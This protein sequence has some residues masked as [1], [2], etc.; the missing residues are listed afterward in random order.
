MSIQLNVVGACNFHR[1]LYSI[2][3]MHENE[4]ETIIYDY[5][6]TDIIGVFWDVPGSFAPKGV[7]EDFALKRWLYIYSGSKRIICLVAANAPHA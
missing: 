7:V 3:R 6:T 1:Q 5:R 2:C 4:P